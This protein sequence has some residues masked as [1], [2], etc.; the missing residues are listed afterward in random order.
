MDNDETQE[1]QI[2]SKLSTILV[3]VAFVLMV[4]NQFQLMGLNSELG[5]TPT[6]LSIVSTSVIP[7]GTPKIY[8]KELGISYDNVNPND[9]QSADATI[10]AMSSLDRT[11][12]L[13]G[14]DLSRYIKIVSE[15]SCEYCCGAKSIIFDDGRPACGCAHSYAMRGLA[16][17]LILNHEN[18]FS[19]DEIL[20][21]LAKWKTL[22]FPGQMQAKA[23]VMKSK[24][25]EF[26]YINLGSN[27]YR[28][29]EK[30]ATSSSGMVGGC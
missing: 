13:T 20:T 10:K 22:Y 29:I 7:T 23:D 11:L 4:F 26:S 25:V 28:N 17:Y 12:T 14:D 27:K 5:S 2:L 16:K 1:K 15:I 19:D 21:E 24:G 18:E 3:V 9:P 30:G 8:G 6:G